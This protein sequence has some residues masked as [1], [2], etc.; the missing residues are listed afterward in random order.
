MKIVEFVSNDINKYGRM[1]ICREALIDERY[2][3]AAED[4]E[5]AIVPEIY[6][7]GD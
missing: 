7:R 2:V 6:E 1:N 4:F 3:I 5:L